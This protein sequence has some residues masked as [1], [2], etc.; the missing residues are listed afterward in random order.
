MLA[1]NCS[2]NNADAPHTLLQR[3]TLP[4][5]ADDDLFPFLDMVKMPDNATGGEHVHV[6]SFAL[7]FDDITCNDCEKTCSWLMCARWQLWTYNTKYVGR[8]QV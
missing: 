3:L 7:R 4:E 2:G 1:V 5:Y 8:A 6:S